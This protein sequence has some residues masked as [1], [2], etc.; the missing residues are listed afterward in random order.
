MAKK[1]GKY[2]TYVVDDD[3]VSH[4]FNEGDEYPSWAEKKI[5]NPLAF[6]GGDDPDPIDTIDPAPSTGLVGFDDGKGHDGPPPQS[7]KG[8]GEPN[9]RAY[10]ED[11][12][13]DTSDLEGRDEIIAR[14]KEEGHPV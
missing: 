11:L 5:T 1:C 6:E 7:G 8:S 4:T 3:G 14:V 10:A 9:W 12:G 2:S 13:V